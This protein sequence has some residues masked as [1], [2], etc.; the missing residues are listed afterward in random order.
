MHRSLETV[1]ADWQS[2]AD[3]ADRIG[4]A[5]KAKLIRTIVREVSDA[6]ADYLVFTSETEAILYSAK[7]KNWL[8]R[9]FAIWE[10]QGN[11]KWN[12]RKLRLYR[13]CVLPRRA[14]IGRTVADAEQEAR[15]DESVRYSA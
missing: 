10:R 1:I 11:A 6:A 15:R 14:E 5:D 12:G 3:A 8:R 9:Q 7:S 4:E 13:R 2:N